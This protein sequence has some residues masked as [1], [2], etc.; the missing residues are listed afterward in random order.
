MR[1][2]TCHG[3]GY[4]YTLMEGRKTCT[5]C[6]GAS[7]GYFNRP[8]GERTIEVRG[9]LTDA[10]EFLGSWPLHPAAHFGSGLGRGPGR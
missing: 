8:E 6:H 3:V 1:C 9:R 5:E 10:D 4:T 2:G 7:R